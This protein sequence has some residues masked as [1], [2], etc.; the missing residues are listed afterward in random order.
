MERLTAER[1]YG[2]NAE[3]LSAIAS[4]CA[5]DNAWMASRPSGHRRGPPE[6]GT[7]PPCSVATIAIESVSSIAYVP[8]ASVTERSSKASMSRAAD[9]ISDA[10]GGKQYL[11]GRSGWATLA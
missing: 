10:I 5:H 8:P 1:S 7:K 11:P 6:H 3:N 2:F 4:T 9:V